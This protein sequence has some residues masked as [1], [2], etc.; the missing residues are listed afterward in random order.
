MR[1]PAERV[2]RSATTRLA[3]A[4]RPCAISHRGDSGMLVRKN[5]VTS[6]SAAP[7]SS[8][9]R[10]ALGP[11]GR[12]ATPTRYAAN[13]PTFHIRLSATTSR[14]RSFGDPNSAVSA[15]EIG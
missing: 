13:A 9:H 11:I 7:T 2:T 5:S 3:S 15:D 4:V 10:H 14:P 1:L 6:A 8:I 12:N